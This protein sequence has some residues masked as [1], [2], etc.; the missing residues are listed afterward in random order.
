MSKQSYLLYSFN[1][2][3]LSPLLDARIDQNKY[4]A[5]CRT[6]Q[7][8]IPLI[9][10]GATRRPGTEYINGAI[11]NSAASRLI[12][13]Q[14]S[15]SVRYM[16]EFGNQVIRVYKDG[17]QL[18]SGGNVYEISTPYLTADL[19]ELKFEQS[20]DIMYITHPEYEPRLLARTAD[21]TWTLTMM[22]HK[23]GPFLDQNTDE[24]LTITPSATTGS[25]TLTASDDLFDEEHAPAGATAT[26]ASNNGALFR[27]S[28]IT[29]ER[30]IYTS[31]AANGNSATNLTVYEGDTL[32]FITSGIWTGVCTVYR[33]YDSG[34]SWETV[35]V[36]QS[37]NNANDKVTLTEDFADALYRTTMSSYSSGTCY[38]RLKARSRLVH[39]YV[40]VTAYTSAT[41][42][43]ATVLDYDSNSHAGLISTDATW[44]WSQGS[45]SD[46]LGWPGCVTIS[47]EDRL[48]LAGSTNQPLTVWASKAGDYQCFKEGTDDADA[49]TWTLAGN[50]QQNQI[51]WAVQ[52][53][54]IFL[55]TSGAEHKLGASDDNEA[56]TPTNVQAKIQTTYGSANLQ[57]ML[58]NDA[59]LFLQR[60]GRKIREA[61]FEYDF[62]SFRADDLSVFSEHLTDSGV[63]EWAFQKSPDPILWMVL[64]NGKIAIM[65]YDRNQQVNSWAEIVT[66][67]LADQ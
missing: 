5:G 57:A 67:T 6:L 61:L 55:G 7:N 42:V 65:S 35:W 56:M 37:S 15:V 1:A 40:Q 39:R 31:H 8:M 17:A 43:T 13:F 38:A 11:S 64:T 34:V 30:E 63:V 52:K 49:V 23:K 20:A 16:L 53:S 19:R 4:L 9:H 51:H 26:D 66:E 18:Y 50:G 58:I 48:I 41:E 46:Y 3:E 32:D 60:G 59:V 44:R 25:I 27:I 33:S 47:S 54:G 22:T 21:T 2:G 12:P 62:G 10:G 45:W 29:E 14:H 24:D 28:H 36:T